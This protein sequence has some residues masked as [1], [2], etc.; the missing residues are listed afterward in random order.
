M[1]G[2]IEHMEYRLRDGVDEAE[3]LAGAREIGDWVAARPGFEYRVLTR[4][5]DGGWLELIFWRDRAAQEAASAAFLE[6]M[7]ACDTL[8]RVDME[9]FRMT[10][11]PVRAFTAPA[12][13]AA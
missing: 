4:R 1:T 7:G 6:Q 2:I 5:E 8:A 12:A 11:L 3:F 10:H 9:S 13:A